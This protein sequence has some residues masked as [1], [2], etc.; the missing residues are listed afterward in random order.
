[1]GRSVAENAQ[2]ARVL[3]GLRR[4]DPCGGDEARA[5]RGVRVK[6][7]S[8]VERDAR[9]VVQAL[10]GLAA[11]LGAG[12][13]VRAS[14]DDERERL[15]RALTENAGAAAAR[16]H[17]YVRE[18]RGPGDGEATPVPVRLGP[19]RDWVPPRGHLWGDP[20]GQ[21]IAELP[22]RRRADPGE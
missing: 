10:A 15:L 9:D 2:R 16:V 3:P 5:L 4:R 14:E 6:D 22:G 20:G 8:A 12:G 17:A 7:L 21:R 1:L 19:W 18:L 11:L 13:A